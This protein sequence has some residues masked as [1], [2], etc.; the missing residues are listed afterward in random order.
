[1]AEAL[2]RILGPARPPLPPLPTLLLAGPARSGR[3]ALLLRCGPAPPARGVLLA[4]R[5]LERL[6][7]GGGARV[8]R[9]HFLYPPTLGDLCRLLASLHEAQPGPP[10]LLLL[11]GLE[12]Y[13]AACPSARAAAR[14]CALLLDAA[15]YCSR[16]LGPDPAGIPGCRLL[17]SLK[18]PAED[19]EALEHLPVVRR[20]FPACCRL[21]PEAPAGTAQRVSVCLSRPGAPDRKWRVEFGPEG[22]MEVFSGTEAQTML[23]GSD[24]W[25]PPPVQPWDS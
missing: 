24:S 4:P 18:L 16:R 3:S 22:E 14:L 10:A 2:S 7:P 12:E 23:P 21:C 1:M 17:V 11:D 9:L 20:Y 13:L 15:S 25:I 8:Q 5:P 6:P 19:P